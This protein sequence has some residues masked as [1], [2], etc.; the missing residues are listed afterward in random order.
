VTPGADPSAASTRLVTPFF[1]VVTASVLA[2]F[3]YIG[4]MIATVPRMIE[5]ALGGSEFDIGLNV[6]VFSLSAIVIRPALSR[7]GERFGLRLAIIGGALVTLVATLTLLVVTSRWMMLPIR[8]VQGIGEAAVFV[9]GTALTTGRAPAHRR[10]EAAS[11]FSVAVFGGIGLGPVIAEAV[12]VQQATAVPDYRPAV[13]WSMLFIVVGAL[14]AALL[15]RDQPSLD[16]PPVGQP[17]PEQPDAA[18]V[19]EPEEARRWYQPEAIRPGLV[20]AFGM[21][22]FSVFNSFLPKHAENIGMSGAGQLFAIYSVVCLV[23]R[24]GFARLPERIGLVRSAVIAL[25]GV[26]GGLAVLAAWADPAGARVAT[27]VIAVGMSFLYPALQA[28]AVNSVDAAHRVRA[29]ATFTMFFEVG[30]VAGGVILGV[31][32]EVTSKRG[33]FAGGAVI[34][35]LGVGFLLAIVVPYLGRTALTRSAAF[36]Q[37]T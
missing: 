28:I 31:L 17:L 35:A 5:D 26:G 29:I 19:N 1:V 9:G 32:A 37:P 25:C 7:F 12:T 24:I 20:L 2:F 13:L 11:Y 6:A 10:A 27:G 15:P 3:L 4:V 21:A 23:I 22:G 33:G 14:I 36:T 34:C 18:V 16:Q 30:S 8:G